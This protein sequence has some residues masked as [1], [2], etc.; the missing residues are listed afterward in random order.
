MSAKTIA[1]MKLV[2]VKTSSTAHNKPSLCP[3][4][5]RVYSPIKRLE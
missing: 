4:F 5:E 3:I 1:M 2:I